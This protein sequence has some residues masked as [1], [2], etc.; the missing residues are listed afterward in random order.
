MA[1]NIANGQAEGGE[2]KK[3]EGAA[4]AAPAAPPKPVAPVLKVD[5]DTDPKESVAFTLLEDWAKRVPEDELESYRIL[6]TRL[7]ESVKIAFANEKTMLKKA[8]Q[9][10]NDILGEKINMEKARIRQTDE[11]ENVERLEREREVSQTNLD[12]AE[13][14]DTVVKYELQELTN[15]HNELEDTLLE[16]RA[17]NER[18][19][20]PELSRL[21][22]ELDQLVSESGA[23]D[24]ASKNE[25]ARQIEL[26]EIYTRLEEDQ[27]RASNE[28]S[29]AKRVLLKAQAEPERIKKQAES[30][31][32]AVDNLAM[33]VTKLDNKVNTCDDEIARQKQKKR[34]AEEVKTNLNHKLELHRDTIE[35]RQ[36]DV[37]AV[38]KNLELEKAKHHQVRDG[39]RGATGGTKR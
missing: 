38:S 21:K 26:S 24:E 5:L 12:E 8:R 11:Q 15:V 37:E 4:P 36:R 20:G 17:D 18:M 1:D 23:T 9:L 35:H 16:L 3:E 27:K 25:K 29:E 33:E 30:V 22:E 39:T 28:M 31:A 10:N 13:H 32:K 7:W 6:Y 2:E 14:A 19:V 34:E